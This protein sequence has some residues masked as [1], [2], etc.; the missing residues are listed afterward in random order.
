MVKVINPSKLR[1]RNK[2]AYK[3]NCSEIVQFLGYIFCVLPHNFA[4]VNIDCLMQGSA[5]FDTV[6]TLIQHNCLN[7]RKMILSV[8]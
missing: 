7:I 4:H 6:T 1:N 8:F 5:V 3:F 2:C